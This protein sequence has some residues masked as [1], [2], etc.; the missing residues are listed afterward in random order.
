[1]KKEFLVYFIDT[2][3]IHDFLIINTDS[4]EKAGE[5]VDNLEKVGE[6]ISVWS[7]TLDME[8]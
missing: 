2:D 1:M 7:K 4:P 5:I 8:K 6:V 3:Y